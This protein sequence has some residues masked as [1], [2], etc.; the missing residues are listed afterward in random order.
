MNLET[1]T[2]KN[3][4]IGGETGSG[5]TYLLTLL[6]NKIME[7][8]DSNLLIYISDPK[9]FCFRRFINNKDILNYDE[10]ELVKIVND[11]LE[12]LKDN[13]KCE[14]SDVYVV[15]DEI[16]NELFFVDNASKEVINGKRK[17]SDAFIDLIT[18]KLSKK[19]KVYILAATQLP[20]LFLPKEIQSKFDYFVELE[21]QRVED[22]IPLLS[23]ELKNSFTKVLKDSFDERNLTLYK[24]LEEENEQL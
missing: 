18:S 16:G 6:I 5:K 23:K 4:L 8:K 10:N 2:L 22:F 7:N 14:F 19:I 17:F 1:L 13:P 3:L 11:R 20:H 24:I 21:P 15:F 12:K 9:L